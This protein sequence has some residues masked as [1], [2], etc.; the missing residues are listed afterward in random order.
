MPHPLPPAAMGND[1]GVGPMGHMSGGV[2]LDLGAGMDRLDNANAMR[3]R[4]SMSA[5]ERAQ[6]SRERN[7]MHARKSRQRKKIALKML[8]QDVQVLQRDNKVCRAGC[9]DGWMDR[10]TDG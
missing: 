1:A 8:Q 2:P 9:M 6:R 7:K 5:A 10:W 3:S 4:G